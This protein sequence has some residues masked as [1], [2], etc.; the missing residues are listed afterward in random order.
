MA[1][2]AVYAQLNAIPALA[3]KVYPLRLPQDVAY[4]AAVYQR[5][6]VVRYPAFGRDARVAHATIQ[7]DVYDNHS[8]GFGSFHTITELVRAALQRQGSGNAIDMMIETERDEFE[9]K[10][11]LLRKSYDIR[12]PYRET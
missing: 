8:T 1:E 5:I 12:V 11:D 3:G 9:D 10:T 7:V 2:A 6:G 4:P